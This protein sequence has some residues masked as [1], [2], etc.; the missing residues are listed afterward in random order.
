MFRLDNFL[1]LIDLELH[2]TIEK[3]F[4]YLLVSEQV[5]KIGMC[6]ARRG[7]QQAS[8]ECC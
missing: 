4:F 1:D 6:F 7:Y 8:F 3:S 2:E 5:S